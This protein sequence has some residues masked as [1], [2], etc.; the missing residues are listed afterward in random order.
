MAS[1]TV[2]EMRKHTLPPWVIADF[3][4]ENAQLNRFTIKCWADALEAAEK[5]V[6]ELE[7]DVA[8]RAEFML[9]DLEKIQ[10]LE[11]EVN[12]LTRMFDFLETGSPGVMARLEEDMRTTLKAARETKAERRGVERE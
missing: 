2:R 6:A 3:G 7:D 12:R 10:R 11:T 1:E 8:E 5:R 4:G 9:G